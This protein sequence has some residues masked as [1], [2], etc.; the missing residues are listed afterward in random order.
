MDFVVNSENI[1][2][3]RKFG[4]PKIERLIASV[5][6]GRDIWKTDFTKTASL[7]T[8]L[9]ELAGQKEIV[10]SNFLPLYHLPVSLESEKI[11]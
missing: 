4:F 10:I 2:N 11:T 8:E 9:F 7:I 3:I 1:E 5:V 6:S